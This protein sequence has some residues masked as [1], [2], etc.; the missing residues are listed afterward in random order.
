M[1]NIIEV[2]NTEEALALRVSEYLLHRGGAPTL[3]MIAGGSLPSTVLPYFNK[4]ALTPDVTIS[5]FDER[6]T[7]DESGLNELL[8][9]KTNF[10]KQAIDAGVNTIDVVVGSM[11]TCNVVAKDWEERIKRWKHEN[12]DGEIIVMAGIGA[13]GHVAGILCHTEKETPIFE[14]SAWIVSHE[15]QNTTHQYPVR[16][17]P[18]FTFWREVVDHTFMY[19]NVPEKLSARLAIE[20]DIGTFHETPG[21]VLRNVTGD[22]VMYSNK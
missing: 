17:T 13:D 10:Y 22:V 8:L 16:I 3:L 2:E 5:I 1:I 15:F 18:T 20:N 21:R 12:H 7:E 19:L 6:C 14:S 11:E 4:Q 9:K